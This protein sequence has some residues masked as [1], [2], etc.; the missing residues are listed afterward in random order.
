MGPRRKSRRRAGELGAGGEVQP[1]RL[2]H[3]HVVSTAQIHGVLP[4]GLQCWRNSIAAIPSPPTGTPR[5]GISTGLQQ[6]R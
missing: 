4:S 6:L 2:T 1:K 3:I 5:C